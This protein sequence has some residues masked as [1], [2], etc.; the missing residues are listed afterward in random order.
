MNQNQEI[1]MVID[2]EAEVRDSLRAFLERNSYLV[3]TATNG[4]SAMDLLLGG[5]RLPDLIISDIAMP[6]MDGYEF[7]R[8]ATRDPRLSAIPFIFLSGRSSVEDVRY[9]KYLGADDYLTKPFQPADLLA[10]IGGKLG[11]KK[12]SLELD[13][14]VSTNL[15]HFQEQG[16]KQQEPQLFYVIW[17]AKAGS[18]VKAYYPSSDNRLYAINELGNQLFSLVTVLFGP[19]LEVKPESVLLNLEKMHRKA[20]VYFDT[21]ADKIASTRSTIFMLGYTSTMISYI[22]S[23]AIKIVFKEI[24]SLIKNRKKWDINA[25]YYQILDKL[26]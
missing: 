4:E 14:K 26:K 12:R 9:G 24:A 23:V 19:K 6:T 22:D 3:I 5:G 25:T 1:I 8:K 11:R 20:Y 18:L 16:G 21:M 10:V 13:R 2:D 7:F 17:D 15:Q